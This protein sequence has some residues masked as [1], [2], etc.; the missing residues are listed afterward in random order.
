VLLNRLRSLLGERCSISLKPVI[1]L[2]A[3][4]LPVDAY[5]IP[6]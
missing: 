2:P 1:D 4:H 3:G 6:S 5:E